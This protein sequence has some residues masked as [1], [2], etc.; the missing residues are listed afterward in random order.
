MNDDEQIREVLAALGLGDTLQPKEKT[1]LELTREAMRRHAAKELEIVY[2][3]TLADVENKLQFGSPKHA[4]M[5]LYTG[6]SD[7]MY[8][9]WDPIKDVLASP[10]AK[11]LFE[12]KFGKDTSI[13]TA[14]RATMLRSDPLSYA[15]KSED[16]DKATAFIKR[17]EAYAEALTK[18]S[19]ETGMT[20]DAILASKEETV[21]IIQTIYGSLDE[22]E[23]QI[24]SQFSSIS[25]T[26]SKLDDLQRMPVGMMLSAM[27]ESR[28]KIEMAQANID[29]A[30]IGKIV[31]SYLGDIAMFGK[32]F[33]AESVRHTLEQIQEYKKIAE[34]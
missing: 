24:T 31:E 16:F 14:L 6:V 21:K 18:H 33:I 3:K 19:Q 5:T 30:A 9:M 7:L 29:P 8:T 32:A 34:Q 15:K 17:Q 11:E 20:P 27:V 4:F 2:L 12:E 13:E 26:V 28:T 23:K 22:Y 25:D 1:P 10:L